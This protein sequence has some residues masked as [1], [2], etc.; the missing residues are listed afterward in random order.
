MFV[1]NKQR[2]LSAVDINFHKIIELRVERQVKGHLIYN[3]GNQVFGRLIYILVAPSDRKP[4][5]IT[6]DPIIN[7]IVYTTIL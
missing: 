6:N 1:R 3:D 4:L 5:S 2:L 7:T